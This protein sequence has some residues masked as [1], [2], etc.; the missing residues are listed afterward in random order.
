MS[1]NERSSGVAAYRLHY[2]LAF[3]LLM[4]ALLVIRLDAPWFGHHDENGAWITTGARNFELYG[5]STL[6]YLPVLKNGP[7]DL[8]RPGEDFTYYVHHP[9]LIVYTVAWARAL[10]GPHEMSARLVSAFS[11]LISL[12][13]LFVIVRRLYNG[14]RALWLL[15][16]YGLTPMIA[17]FGRMPNHEP[18]ALSFI[19]IFVAVFINWL[20]APNWPRWALLAIMAG[21]ALWTAWAAAFFFLAFGLAGLWLGSWPQ[22]RQMVLLGV[23]IGGLTL[24]VVAFYQW[25]W[26]GTLDKL[27]D[28]FFYR[29]SSLEM[30]RDGESFG[31]L[32]FIFQQLVHMLPLMTFA[33]VVLGVAG[34]LLTIRREGRQQRAVILALVGGGLLYMLVFRNAFYIHDYYKIYFMPGLTIAATVAM[35]AGWRSRRWRRWAR[36]T[37]VGLVVVSAIVSVVFFVLLHRSGSTQEDYAM[38]LAQ[39]V[40]QNSQPHSLIMTNLIRQSSAVEHYAQRSMTW[41]ITPQD[42]LELAAAHRESWALYVYCV[43]DADDIADDGLF[44]AALADLPYE[45]F[46]NCRVIRLASAAN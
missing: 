2:L 27:R 38:G 41:Q 33:I 13:A 30:R 21:L 35:V 28:A 45:T 42:A 10:L 29:T 17:Y 36:P 8:D 9:P 15:P 20:R 34:V 1:A 43:P 18:L 19:L 26:D 31:L 7:L 22:R 5:W 44:D 11:T 40:A 37:V 12:A 46:E 32:E 14:R 24:S 4:W 6:N 39:A 3:L 16:L 23:V 25:Q